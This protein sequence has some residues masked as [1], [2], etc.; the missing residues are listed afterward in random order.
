M[1]CEA[2]TKLLTPLCE[3]LIVTPLADCGHYSMQEAP[4][5]LVA[6]VE[7]FLAGDAVNVG[8]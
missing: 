4:P 5:L 8:A 1:R 3:R 2:M 7:R 6:I